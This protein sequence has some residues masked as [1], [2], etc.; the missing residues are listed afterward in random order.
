[1]KKTGATEHSQY[2]SKTFWTSTLRPLLHNPP[3][4]I[5]KQKRAT[6]DREFR[7]AHTKEK[8]QRK[9]DAENGK[10]WTQGKSKSIRSG[11]ILSQFQ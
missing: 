10:S 5:R 6:Y 9:S 2:L 4:N 3:V 8:V 11:L 1:M 7:K